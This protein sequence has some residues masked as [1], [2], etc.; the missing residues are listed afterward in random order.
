MKKI[1]VST[2]LRG[3]DIIIGENALPKSAGDICGICTGGRACVVSDENVWKLYGRH[4]TDVLTGAGIQFFEIVLSPGEQSKSM[5]TVS[6][7]CGMFARHGLQRRDPVIAFG[8]GTVGDTAGFAASVYMRGV[9]LIQIPTTLTA[10]A[11]SAVGGKT[12]VNLAE[13]KNLA[14]SFYQPSLVV[15]DLSLLR[16]LDEREMK[17]GLA[18]IIKYAVIG[19]DKIYE[20]LENSQNISDDLEQ[21]VYLSCRFKGEFTEADEYDNAQR[22]L[23]NFGHTFAHA[24]EKY[25]GYGTFSHGEAV[26]AGMGYALR[27]S[28][29][30]KLISSGQ[31]QR[32]AA[33]AEKYG[34]VSACGTDIKELINLMKADKKNKGGNISLV[35]L[36]GRT[37]LIREISAADLESALGADSDE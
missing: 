26:A 27:V 17:S 22:R 21:I 4:I 12:A 32:H 10:Q 5:E 11:D 15:S 14:G 34:L 36:S 9:P 35:L 13:G 8:G 6:F 2:P 20:I 1:R 33:L 19:E 16:T 24:I 7:L 18:E 37:A 31:A 25:S 28:E 29:H 3:Y 30:L 23:L